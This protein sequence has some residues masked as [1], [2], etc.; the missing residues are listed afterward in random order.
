MKLNLILTETLKKCPLL[1]HFFTAVLL[2]V[3]Q[4]LLLD[5]YYVS[6]LYTP[7]SKLPPG[8]PNSAGVV[9]SIC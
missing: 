3:F 9:L 4:Y 8:D 5:V 1:L 6:H 7:V 2:H